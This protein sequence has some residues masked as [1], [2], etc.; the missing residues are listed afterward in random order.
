MNILTIDEATQLSEDF[1]LYAKDNDAF[2]QVP[3]SML[4]NALYGGKINLMKEPFVYPSTQGAQPSDSE[5][6]AG[7]LALANTMEERET[8]IRF[9]SGSGGGS[10]R[11]VQITKLNSHYFI[12]HVTLIAVGTST[13]Y[14]YIDGA[15]DVR[16]VGEYITG[17][18]YGATTGSN[19]T[20]KN[21]TWTS[22]YS[23]VIPK[24]RWRLIAS[25]YFSANATGI[26][27]LVLSGTANS[28]SGDT[29]DKRVALNGATT[30]MQGTYEFDVT[31]DITRYLAV[32]QNSG[33]DLTC[34]VQQFRLT[35]VN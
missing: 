19:R 5:I 15:W 3:K 22:L 23:I 9:F 33:S 2:V 30:W 21:N 24:G 31:S 28:G 32:Y 10:A 29:L 34:T 20:V 14:R 11:Y 12:A 13:T 26:R 35:R 8:Q 27:N 7:L 25:A 17:T 1:N 16:T 18:P 4:E 6:K